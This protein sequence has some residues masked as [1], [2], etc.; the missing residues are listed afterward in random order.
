VICFNCVATRNPHGIW[1]SARSGVRIFVYEQAFRFGLIFQK[2]QKQSKA[3][4]GKQEIP[5][6][7]QA[8]KFIF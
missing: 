4:T 8:L 7:M 1:L 2:H 6:A 5:S 3:F